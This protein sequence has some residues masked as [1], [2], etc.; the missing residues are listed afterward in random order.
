[1][2]IQFA[3]CNKART[4]WTPIG[5]MFPFQACARIVNTWM[6]LSTTKKGT[7]TISEYLGRMKAFDGGM[8]SAGKPVN[9]DDM[10]SYI[11][12]GVDFSYMS[13]ISSIC[14]RTE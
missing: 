11:L 4:A 5:E 10:V 2:M 13:F 3:H 14:T 6:A 8:A 7:V 12:A 1:M 9:D